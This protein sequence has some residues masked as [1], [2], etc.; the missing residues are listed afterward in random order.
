M[1]GID[2]NVLLRFLLNDEPAQ[3]AA[4]KAFVDRHTNAGEEVFI[5][6]AVLCETVWVLTRGY[7]YGKDAVA[8]LLDALIVADGFAIEDR[9]EVAE[10]LADWR[11]G[12]PGFADALIGQTNTR[13]GCSATLTFDR[14]AARLADFQLLT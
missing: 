4:A 12:G 14:K 11:N 9:A 13:R 10:A 8:D 2:T 5:N 7:R 6:R 1:K 3:S